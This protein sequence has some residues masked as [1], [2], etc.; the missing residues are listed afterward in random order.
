MTQ[1]RG[2]CSLLAGVAL[3]LLVSQTQWEGPAPLRQEWGQ[4]PPAALQELVIHQ[5][6]WSSVSDGSICIVNGHINN[7]EIFSPHPNLLHFSKAVMNCQAEKNVGHKE[8][9]SKLIYFYYEYSSFSSLQEP[10][11]AAQSYLPLC[12]LNSVSNADLWAPL[13]SF[14]GNL[15]AG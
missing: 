5:K 14:Y 1:T 9:V 10:S 15:L 12:C 3:H 7:V 6:L 13:D 8:L 11:F 2:L 4:L